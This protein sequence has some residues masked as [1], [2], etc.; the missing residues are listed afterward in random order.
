LITRLKAAAPKIK[1]TASVLLILV[2]V[3]NIYTAVNLDLFLNLL[4]P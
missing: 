3:F 1:W 2:G 4:F